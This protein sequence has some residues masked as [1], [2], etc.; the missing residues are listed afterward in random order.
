M[1]C[2]SMV[3]FCLYQRVLLDSDRSPGSKNIVAFGF[4]Y[5]IVPWVD[6]VGYASCFGTQAGIYVA[7]I[8]IGSAILIPFGAKIRHRQAQWRIIV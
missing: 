1:R 3:S 6:K 2:L 8:V 7:V 4:L 5:G